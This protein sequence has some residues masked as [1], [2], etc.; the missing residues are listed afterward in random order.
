MQDD[1]MIA[2]ELNFAFGR[3]RVDVSRREIL[4][5]GARIEL[6][7]RAFDILLLLMMMM[8]MEARG[9]LVSKAELLRRVWGDL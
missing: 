6:G 5:G 4:V 9:E 8:M 7:S 1:C 2:G 3:F